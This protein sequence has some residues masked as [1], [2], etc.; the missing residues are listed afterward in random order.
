[1]HPMS[2][3]R[4]KHTVLRT[5][6]KVI[7]F[8]SAS[9][10][11]I[12]SEM[13][14]CCLVTFSSISHWRN[15]PLIQTGPLMKDCVNRAKYFLKSK[16]KR[17]QSWPLKL[18]PDCSHSHSNVCVFWGRCD[19]KCWCA[20]EKAEPLVEHINKCLLFCVAAGKYDMLWLDLLLCAVYPFFI[21][22]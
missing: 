1:M 9:H 19:T 17:H 12:L 6:A 11:S 13:V 22:M 4:A 7:M 10:Q 5:A 20:V 18:L 16:P 21:I 2:H 3:Y 14:A 15:L 8:A